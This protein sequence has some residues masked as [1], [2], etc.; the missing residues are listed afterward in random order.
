MKF[1]FSFLAVF[2][3]A[4]FFGF[5][6]EHESQEDASFDP[7]SLINHHIQ[8]AHS[9]EVLHGVMIHLPVIVYSSEKGLDIFSSSN[10]IGD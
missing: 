2:M 8:D 6:S 3:M 1:K 10:F 7:G 9:W 5:S 4:S